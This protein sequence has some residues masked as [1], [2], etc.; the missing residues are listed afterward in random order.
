MD[1]KP[2]FTE[3]DSLTKKLVEVYGHDKTVVLLKQV[4]S[5]RTHNEDITITYL[6]VVIAEL[7]GFTFDEV[8]SGTG[9]EHTLAKK[10]AMYIVKSRNDFSFNQTGRIFNNL[11]KGTSHKH[12]TEME[13]WLNTSNRYN[14]LRKKYTTAILRV[15]QFVE[16]L[17]Q[18]EKE[19]QDKSKEV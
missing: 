10:L 6:I 18:K 2:R 4:T 16:S 3:L 14:D 11:S 7:F 13:S 15:E 8:V 12:I 1:N 19:N 17:E 5:F 9:R